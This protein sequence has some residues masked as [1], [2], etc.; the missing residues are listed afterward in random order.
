MISDNV[1]VIMQSRLQPLLKKVQSYLQHKCYK[2]KFSVRN[3]TSADEIQMN[4][5]LTLYSHVVEISVCGSVHT[6]MIANFFGYSVTLRF[7]DVLKNKN[8]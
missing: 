8:Y 6:F 3:N 4:H 1:S 7:I 2:R 5:C